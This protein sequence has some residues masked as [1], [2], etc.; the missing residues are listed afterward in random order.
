MKAITELKKD[1]SRMVLTADKGVSLVVMDTA[2]YKKKAELLQQP[3]YQ[4]IPTDPTSK[5]KKQTH[6]DVEIHQGR[7]GYQ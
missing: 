3:T 7:R 4:P 2:E 6:Q 1:P 5:Y